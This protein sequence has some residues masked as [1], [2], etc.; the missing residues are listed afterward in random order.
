MRWATGSRWLGGSGRAL[1]LLKYYKSILGF[2]K[3]TWR[4]SAPS[5]PR[6]P[7]EG[8]LRRNDAATWTSRPLARSAAA[9]QRKPS[10]STRLCAIAA[11]CQRI[12]ECG[13]QVSLAKCAS[14]LRIV[15]KR[16]NLSVR[17]HSKNVAA[18]HVRNYFRIPFNLNNLR[19]FPDLAEPG[20]F[21]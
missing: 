3:S 8:L 5:A 20:I 17:E 12:V 4:A 10:R 15:E 2:R 13:I 6:N 18:L 14:Y 9:R 16:Y 1:I 7:I 19:I 21:Q 11:G